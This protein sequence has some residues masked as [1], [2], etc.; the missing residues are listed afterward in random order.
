MLVT[1]SYQVT[2]TQENR[3]IHRLYEGGNTGQL[4]TSRPQKQKKS[5]KVASSKPKVVAPGGSESG[6][7]SMPTIF[8]D[9]GDDLQLTDESDD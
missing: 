9:L 3:L 5:D 7:G 2:Q 4:P 6:A 8:T 1:Y